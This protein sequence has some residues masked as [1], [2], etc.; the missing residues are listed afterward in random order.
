MIK[1]II[2]TANF[3]L[4]FGSKLRLYLGLLVSRYYDNYL[5]LY[6]C[7]QIFVAPKTNSTNYQH[8]NHPI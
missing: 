4:I 5:L 7:Q 3:T 1:K 2:I 8:F 6:I